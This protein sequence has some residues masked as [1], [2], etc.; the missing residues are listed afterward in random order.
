MH[1]TFLVKFIGSDNNKALLFTKKAPS[2]SLI[3]DFFPL[4]RLIKKIGFDNV[5]LDLNIDDPI[6]FII[7]IEHP[8]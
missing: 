2:I 6:M 5:D 4:N 8:N 1:K 3:Y 7:I